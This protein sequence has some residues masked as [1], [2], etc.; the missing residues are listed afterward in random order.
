MGTKGHLREAT[1][2]LGE[3]PPSTDDNLKMLPSTA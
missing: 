2:L 1:G 3:N